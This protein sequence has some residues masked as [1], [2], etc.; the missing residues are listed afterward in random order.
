MAKRKVTEGGAGEL[1]PFAAKLKA[2]RT[3][4]GLTQE[5][6]AEKAGLHLGAIFKLEQG[7]REPAWSTVQALCRALGVRCDEFLDDLPGEP[8]GESETPTDDPPASTPKAQQ[9]RKGT[10]GKGKRKEG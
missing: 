5:Q 7:R 4:M 3:R 10:T 1:P 9:Q 2:I 8:S 6:L